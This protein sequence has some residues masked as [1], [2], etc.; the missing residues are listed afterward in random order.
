MSPATALTYLRKYVVNTEDM[1]A[2]PR[3]LP[4]FL[5]GSS[6]VLAAIGLQLGLIAAKVGPAVQLVGGLVGVL[7]GVLTAVNIGYGIV[8]RHQKL[9]LLKAGKDVSE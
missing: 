8:I 4:V 7:V 2:D 6:G 3:N 9:R 5:K 1:T